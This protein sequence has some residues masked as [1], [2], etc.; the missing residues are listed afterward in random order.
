MGQ[1]CHVRWPGKRSHLHD[2]HGGH[3]LFVYWHGHSAVIRSETYGILVPKHQPTANDRLIDQG[4]RDQLVHE[5]IAHEGFFGFTLGCAGRIGRCGHF[6]RRLRR[7]DGCGFLRWWLPS[8]VAAPS[9]R[10]TEAASLT[11]LELEL[12]LS[13]RCLAFLSRCIRI[14]LTLLDVCFSAALEREL[15]GASCDMGMQPKRVMARS[16]RAARVCGAFW[17]SVASSAPV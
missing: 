13:Y 11:F 16:S 10:V 7:F 4:H 8:V 14:F 3:M 2:L 12:G 5:K 1:R 17:A 9:W 15:P 6:R